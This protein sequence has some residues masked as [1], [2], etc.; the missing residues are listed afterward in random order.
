MGQ[1]SSDFS[2]R[3]TTC[4]KA[5]RIAARAG[6]GEQQVNPV[7]PMRMPSQAEYKK[8]IAS[9][10]RAMEN[11]MVVQTRGVPMTPTSRNRL[12]WITFLAVWIFTFCWVSSTVVY[13]DFECCSYCGQGPYY[14]GGFPAWWQAYGFIDKARSFGPSPLTDGFS[15]YQVNGYALFNAVILAMLPSL[16]LAGLYGLLK[17]YHN[18]WKKSK[19]WLQPAIRM[20]LAVAGLTLTM[21]LTTG[22]G[23]LYGNNYNDLWLE[24]FV[25]TGPGSLLIF[26]AA[27]VGS[28][29]PEIR[30]RMAQ[31]RERLA[32]L[33]DHEWTHETPQGWDQTTKP[34]DAP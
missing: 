6:L 17:L 30:Q 33:R 13:Q 18:G 34:P 31:R 3:R 19:S 27:I 32:A 15:N 24:M 9:A 21:E 11:R 12:L 29:W 5:A 16:M 25:I 26:S 22:R 23:W 4:K 28:W 14:G 20:A 2:H 8:Y 10:T 7:L 1:E